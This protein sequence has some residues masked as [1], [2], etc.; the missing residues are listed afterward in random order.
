MSFWSKLFGGGGGS[1]GEAK[2]AR[3][4]EYKGFIIEARPF[5]DG[6]QFQLAGTISKDGKV[7]KFIRADKFTD[8]DEA[9][10]FA[11]TKGQLIVDQVGERMFE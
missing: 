10:S 4:E 5:K 3:S 8:A 1:V 7:H 11:I 6:G 2:P 9:A